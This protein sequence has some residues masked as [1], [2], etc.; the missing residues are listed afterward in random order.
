[1]PSSRRRPSSRRLI[2]LFLAVLV[3]PAI[4]LIWLG[5]RVADQGRQLLTES[6]RRQREAAAEGVA[7][8]LTEGVQV[9]RTSLDAG[10]P[11]QGSARLRLPAS[12]PA[13]LEPANAFAWTPSPLTV[14]EAETQL[15]AQAELEEFRR[16]GDRGRT[17]YEAFAESPD[18]RIRAGALLRLARVLRAGH[19]TDDVIRT[20]TRLAGITGVAFAGTPGDLLARRA[21][22][23]VYEQAKRVSDLAACAT[24][25]ERDLIA[26]RWSLDFG[27]WHLAVEQIQRW[28]NRPVQISD[29]RWAISAAADRIWRETR[30]SASSLPAAGYRTLETDHGLITV[31]FTTSADGLTATLIAPG[32]LNRW[33]DAESVRVRQ[34]GLQ[35][36]LLDTDRRPIRGGAPPRS[37]LV[38]TRD[39]SIT[40]L[41]WH[42]VISRTDPESVPGS[43]M[44][45]RWT[46]SAGLAVIVLFIAGGGLLMWRVMQ[47]ELAVAR[48]Q[49]EFVSAVSHEF[50]T[51]LTSLQHV[52]DLLDEDDVLPPERRTALYRVI[53][54]STARLSGLVESLLDFARMEGGRRPYELRPHDAGQLVSTTVREF[55]QQLE[56]GEVAIAAEI[57]PGDLPIRADEAALG[58]AVWNLLENAVKY[59]DPPCVIDVA[60]SRRGASIAIAVRDRGRG[61]PRHEQRD[62]FQKFVRG[63]DA[64]GRRVP[65]TGLG[66]AIVSHIVQA[67][68]G[69]IELES[70][71]GAGSTFTI[72]L[73]AMLDAGVTASIR[74]QADVN[75][76]QRGG[77]AS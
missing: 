52:A 33:F 34:S 59:S 11:L 24:A 75:T 37:P 40:G 44:A 21:T 66:L 65:G 45:G 77:V 19:R 8:A 46:L 47:R 16:S 25:L 41:P 72:T 14:P 38:T 73:P 20:Y 43:E 60:V 15:F 6:E 53:G 74:D 49:T 13:A 71:Q 9:A 69:A 5:A 12:G 42:I 7:L 57:D 55:R 54:R 1:M 17:R 48:L 76:I 63:A 68:A 61:I 27:A 62:V 39:A 67:H 36:A 22:C 28:L 30:S 35:L 2:A 4:A 18:G 3:P 10:R 23:G 56:A 70:T 32:L 64:V 51:P 50:R 58:R 31:A 26:G 29:D